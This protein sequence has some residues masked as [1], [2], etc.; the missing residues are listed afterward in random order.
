VDASASEGATICV[1]IT[2][3]RRIARPRMHPA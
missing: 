1:V 2:K 3:A